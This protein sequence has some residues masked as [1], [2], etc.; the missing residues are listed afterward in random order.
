MFNRNMNVLLSYI[1]VFHWWISKIIQICTTL[2]IF[3]T[4]LQK[5][6]SSD[7]FPWSG[8][9]A[10]NLIDKKLHCSIYFSSNFIKFFFL[11]LTTKLRHLIWLS[12]CILPHLC[13][14]T[15]QYHYA[16]VLLI[17]HI[18]DSGRDCVNE[19]L[20][21][22]QV[23]L[24]QMQTT[25]IQAKVWVILDQQWSGENKNWARRDSIYLWHNWFINFVLWV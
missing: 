1:T 8:A 24:E 16:S 19:S 22:L 21:I 4:T 15:I 23:S 12:V 6:T 7:N 2:S 5:M 25:L 11:T 18:T 3:L 13:S 14:S 9:Y 17:S 10:C 20:P